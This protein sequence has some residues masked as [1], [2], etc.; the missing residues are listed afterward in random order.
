MQDNRELYAV[1]TGDL[2]SSSDMNYSD[3]EVLLS[4]MHDTFSFINNQFHPAGELSFPFEISR[5]DSF[6]TLLRTPEDAL[7]ASVLLF[8]KLGFFS[9]INQKIASRI[10]IGIGSVEYIPES[11]S[12]GEAD[13]QA[14]RLSGKTL[15]SM[16]E[17]EKH[18]LISTASPA[19]N[20]MLE[21]QCA[22]FDNMAARWT[23]IQ[24]EILF[25][26]LGGLTQDEIASKL[27]KSQ[28]T[29]SQSLK[30]AGFDA[31]KKFLD[32]YASLFEYPDIFSMGNK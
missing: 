17:Q 15:D 23:D 11:G 20:L 1:I 28:S 18:L 8:L 22:F 10:S 24:K 32:N 19:L 31:L 6:Q 4:I 16:K 21:S 29:V 2:I 3:R 27:G 26:K 25:E 12:V 14:F 30:A 9:K 5:G 7:L 13:G